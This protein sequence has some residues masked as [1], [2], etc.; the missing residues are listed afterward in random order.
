MLPFGSLFKIMRKSHLTPSP[1]DPETTGVADLLESCRRLM[2]EQD[3]LVRAFES[4]SAL[5]PS[6]SEISTAI[7]RE[8]ESSIGWVTCSLLAAQSNRNQAKH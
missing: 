2:A 5:L 4:E 6:S 3:K 7:E 1:N 8:L